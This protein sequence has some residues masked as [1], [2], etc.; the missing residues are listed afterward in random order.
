MIYYINRIINYQAVLV[1]QVIYG[2]QTLEGLL[3]T[4]QVLIP[5]SRSPTAK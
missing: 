5:I 4:K 1:L 2:I 3:C